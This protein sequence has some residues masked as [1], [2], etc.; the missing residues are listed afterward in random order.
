[1]QFFQIPFLY[2]ANS[3]GLS[4]R[5]GNFRRSVRFARQRDINVY[6]MH[7]RARGENLN[8]HGGVRRRISSRLAAPRAQI[9]Q[10]MKQKETFR[11]YSAKNMKWTVS[12]KEKEKGSYKSILQNIPKNSCARCVK[13]LTESLHNRQK[14]W[15]WFS[16]QRKRTVIGTEF[17]I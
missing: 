5:T 11:F 1:M 12:K 17:A 3:R 6:K 15:F 13:K 7:V 16:N 10:K 2:Y 9:S 4:T 14:N 8:G